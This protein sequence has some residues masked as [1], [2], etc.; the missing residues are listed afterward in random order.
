VRIR[1]L[2]VL[3][4]LTLSLAPSIATAAGPPPPPKPLPVTSHAPFIAYSALP[5]SEAAGPARAYLGAGDI[6]IIRADSTDDHAVTS[7]PATEF[8]PAFSPDG[9]MIAFS[10]DRADPASGRTDIWLVKPD[11]TGLRR[12]TTNLNARGPTWSPDGKRI[13]MSSDTGI[14]TISA[15]GK[16]PVPVTTNNPEHTDFAPAWTADST[17]LVF[18]RTSLVNGAT[19]GQTLWTAAATGAGAHALLGN[20]APSGYLSQPDVSVDGKYVVF[21]QADAS[22]TGIWLAD[23]AGAVI[24]RLAFSTSGYLNTPVFSPDGKWVLFTHSGPDGRSPSS[25]RL[26]SID[27]TKTKLVARTKQG[28][29]YAP[30]WDR[31]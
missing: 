10:S 28:N 11:G 22:G 9:R 29:Y 31:A 30:S 19:K 7:G 21:L 25:M 12:L 4:G 5:Y 26:V 18:T 2:T 27:G 24:R 1:V 13:A 17:H 16:S 14:T 6:R 15:T 3:A 23:L 20:T 8:E